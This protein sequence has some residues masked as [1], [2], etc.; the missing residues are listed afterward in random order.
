MQKTLSVSNAMGIAGLFVDAK[1][2]HAKGYY[3]QFGFIGL[4]DQLDNMF[5][6]LSTIYKSFGTT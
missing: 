6:P 1:H 3:Q 5:L 4:P 2:Q